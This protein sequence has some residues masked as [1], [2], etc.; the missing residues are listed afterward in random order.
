[1]TWL[2]IWKDAVSSTQMPLPRYGEPIHCMCAPE[3]G[4]HN[5]GLH[6]VRVF[7]KIEC[8]IIDEML[9]KRML[10]IDS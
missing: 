7:V 1:M 2:F 9:N 10:D 6:T 8:R 5:E 4:F 3:N